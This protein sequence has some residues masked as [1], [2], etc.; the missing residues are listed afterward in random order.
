MKIEKKYFIRRNLDSFAE[1][2]F[3]KYLLRKGVQPFYPFKDIGID[4]LGYNNGKVELY[5]LKARRQQA[6][7]K[8]LYWFSVRKKDIEKLLNFKNAFFVFCA[9]QP[10][11]TFHFFKVPIKIVKKYFE[12]RKTKKP[13]MEFFEIEKIDEEKYDIRPKYIKIDIN[14]FLAK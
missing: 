1:E 11:Y 6:R 7:N 5:Q 14:K 10:N 8:N 4:M 2:E 9:L 3:A 13:E 12:R